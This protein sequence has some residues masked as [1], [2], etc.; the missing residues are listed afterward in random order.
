VE[1]YERC[2]RRKLLSYSCLCEDGQFRVIDSS[3]INQPNYI[4]VVAVQI[5]PV[6]CEKAKRFKVEWSFMNNCYSIGSDD[7]T[8]ALLCRLSVET[9][10]HKA[11]A[12]RIADLMEEVMP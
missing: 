8:E 1:E 12:Q 10:E 5:A 3:N 6:A 2:P 9:P 7:Y 11:I 4:K